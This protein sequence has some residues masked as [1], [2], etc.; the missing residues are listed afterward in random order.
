MIHNVGHSDNVY[1]FPEFICMNLFECYVTLSEFHIQTLCFVFT[2]G[3]LKDTT[4]KL[5]MFAYDHHE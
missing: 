4:K 1:I 5:L 3:Y 2:L